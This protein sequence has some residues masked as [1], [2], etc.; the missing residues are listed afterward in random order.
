MEGTVGTA[1]CTYHNLEV[2][3]FMRPT[4]CDVCS[5][6]LTGLYKQGLTCTHCNLFTCHDQ[7]KN[8]LLQ[9]KE[10]SC[11]VGGQVKLV[12]GRVTADGGFIPSDV[13][14]QKGSF[15]Q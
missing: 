11:R 14:D 4:Y 12:P 10:G 2:Q 3:S 13:I 8:A 15:Q 7:C 1:A 5:E 9:A 6:L